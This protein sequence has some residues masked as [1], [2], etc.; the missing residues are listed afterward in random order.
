MIHVITESMN[1]G[2][3]KS[4]LKLLTLLEKTKTLMG[5]GI[6]GDTENDKTRR[7]CM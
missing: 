4:G 5:S 2:G 1:V 7:G 3:I 6:S